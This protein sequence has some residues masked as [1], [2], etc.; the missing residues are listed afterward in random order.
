[1]LQAPANHRR[2]SLAAAA[3]FALVALGIQ[4]GA[5][6]WSSGFG[7][8]P[9]ESAHFVG[10][11]LTR[12][13][14]AAGAPQW[15]TVYAREY[16]FHRP[17]FAIGYWPPAF[18]ILQGA[19]F[20]LGGVGRQ[21]ALIFS[22]AVA[23]LLAFSIFWVSRGMAS[24]VRSLLAGLLFLAIPIVQ[25]STCVVMTDLLVGLACLWFSVILARFLDN[26]RKR[27][28]AALGLICATA[29]LVK[30][31]SL[32]IVSVAA[33][34]ILADRRFRLLT[35]AP[36]A[37]AVAVAAAITGPWIALTHHMARIGFYQNSGN[38]FPARL[39]NLSTAAINDIGWPLASILTAASLYVLGNWRRLPTVGKAFAVHPFAS[40]LLVAWAPV[41]AESR[42][43]IP[44]FA[45]MAINLPAAATLLD[46]RFHWNGKFTT[47]ALAI[48]VAVFGAWGWL[49]F[50]PLP[51]DAVLRSVQWI[52]AQPSLAEAAVLVPTSAE[53]PTVASFAATGSS[54]RIV[55]RPN[56]LLA[57]LDW[58][59]SNY[60]PKFDSAQSV[61]KA[62]SEG[63][64]QILMLST[65]LQAELV[66][67]HDRFLRE[68]V[69]D[70]TAGW[71]LLHT[72]K[73]PQ[74]LATIEVYGR[75]LDPVPGGA[76][77]QATLR[78]QL[79]GSNSLLR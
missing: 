66:R 46:R 70:P 38:Q 59:A 58:L 30:Y 69:A 51:S 10:A 49:R 8:Y 24:P 57:K 53:G 76:V 34:L 5:H 74:S 79:K 60:Q 11:V 68:I 33:A 31:S 55:V 39:Y 52:E 37:I 54:R 41:G 28:G 9:D 16:Y 43:A 23:A 6:S 35:M 62:L 27:T 45:A 44:A 71:R 36:L 78:A 75:D 22:A 4:H 56:K 18:H 14:L 1:M 25:W 7:A 72:Q 73:D 63:P 19:A 3:L 20:L 42:Y 47:V 13:Y 12:D 26:P 2:R 67:P 21:Q 48:L 32:F 61:A 77:R 40:L 65:G 15:P 17:F 64:I 29:L 50:A